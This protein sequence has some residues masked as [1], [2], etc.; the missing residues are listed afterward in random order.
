M[1]EIVTA[2]AEESRRV[3]VFLGRL[4]K[5]GDVVGLRGDLGAGKTVFTQGIGEGL[6]V[7]D[8][9]TSPT[10]TLINQYEGVLPLYH[11]D[12]YRLEDPEELLE[13]GYEEYFYGEGVTVIEWV[14]NI[15]EYLPECCLVVYLLQEQEEV[16]ENDTRRMI[17]KPRSKRFVQVVEELKKHVGS[18]N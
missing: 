17:F 15:E 10:F 7:K 5:K 6:Q 9:V 16:S 11:F 4:L 14:E 2:S 8:Y 1:L 18:G 3:G 13:L 12:V